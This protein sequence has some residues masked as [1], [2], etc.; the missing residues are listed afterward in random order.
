[1]SSGTKNITQARG[2]RMVKFRNCFCG[3]QSVKFM[4]GSFLCQKHWEMDR[5]LMF[6]DPEITETNIKACNARC[7][8]NRTAR[9]KAAGLCVTCGQRPNYT[10][11]TR[12]H[13]CQEKRRA[14]H[15]AY[16]G[17]KLTSPHPWKIANN[18]LFRTLSKSIDA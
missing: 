14:Y 18:M 5:A 1:M 11:C 12:C 2:R 15:H 4:A 10:G 7:E 3:V 9:L 6:Q 13:Q 17:K 16:R 8:K